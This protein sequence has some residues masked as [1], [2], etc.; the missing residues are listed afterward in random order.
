MPAAIFVPP[1]EG[2]VEI[3][4]AAVGAAPA[5]YPPCSATVTDRCIQVSR[6]RRRR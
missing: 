3:A 6:S 5:S 4:V 1:P 2:N